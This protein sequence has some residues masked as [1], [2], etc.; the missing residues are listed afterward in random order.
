MI[1]FELQREYKVTL[2]WQQNTRFWFGP[3]NV[4]QFVSWSNS[5][6]FHENILHAR[7][8]ICAVRYYHYHLPSLNINAK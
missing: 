5:Q 4:Q 8:L 3:Q 7:E 2:R 1:L 6:T